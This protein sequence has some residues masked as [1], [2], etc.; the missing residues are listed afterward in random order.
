MRG[1][2]RVACVVLCV[3]MSSRV[4]WAQAGAAAPAAAPATAEAPKDPLGRDTPRGTVLEFMSAVQKKNTEA[5]AL[6]LNTTLRDHDAAELAQK[7]YVVLDSRLPARLNELSDR[8]EGSRDNPL[9]PDRDVIGVITTTWGTLD[10]VV[11]RVNRGKAGRVWLFSAQ[12]LDSIP[13]VYD[14]IN[15]VSIDRYLP[16]FFTKHRLAGIRLFEWVVLGLAI[17]L[18]YVLIG[19]LSRVFGPVMTAWHR[20]Y[21]PADSPPPDRLPGF[22]RLVVLAAV[23]RWLLGSLD[24]P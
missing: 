6:Y 10:L 15:L 23:I 9:K 20:R 16:A 12:T 14:E 24:L 3:G 1:G 5:A 2:I 8:P 11:E 19:F 13:E 21:G 17:P 4:V 22:V 18:S 7:L